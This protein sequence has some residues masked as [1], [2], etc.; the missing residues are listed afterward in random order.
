MA[1]QTSAAPTRKMTT[2]L[3]GIPLLQSQIG[4]GI[5]E[6]WPQIVPTAFAGPAF[7][8]LVSAAVSAALVGLIAYF[9]PDGPNVA[10]PGDYGKQKLSANHCASLS[11]HPS[12]P[13][14]W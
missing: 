2:L 12:T 8:A 13:Y 7:T 1:V 10:Q 3:I 14:G 9:V 5:T 4:P 6:S 11:A